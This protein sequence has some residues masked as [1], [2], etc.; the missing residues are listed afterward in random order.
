[1]IE[2]IESFRAK[3]DVEA[4]LE[5]F[6]MPVQDMLKLIREGIR[7]RDRDWHGARWCLMTPTDLS[8]PGWDVEEVVGLGPEGCR[9]QSAD[10]RLPDT[11]HLRF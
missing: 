7:V 8:K 2:D 4:I 10:P 11:I 3:L 5:R 1:M 6:E 9:S